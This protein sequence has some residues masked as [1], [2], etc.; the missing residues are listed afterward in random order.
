MT[1]IALED[2][3][4]SGMG[5]P[6]TAREVYDDDYGRTIDVYEQSPFLRV[7]FN[8]R[9]DT[10]RAS[11]ESFEKESPPHMWYNQITTLK[12]QLKS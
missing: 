5:R 11:F 7:V 6:K 9:G 8:L 3:V 2:I 1:S 4:Q 12:Y 10:Y